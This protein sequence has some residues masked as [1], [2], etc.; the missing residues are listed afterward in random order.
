M[1]QRL[2]FTVHFCHRKR[3][4]QIVEPSS[5]RY[6]RTLVESLSGSNCILVERSDSS[7]DKRMVIVVGFR[8]GAHSLKVGLAI[9]QAIRPPGTVGLTSLPMLQAGLSAEILPQPAYC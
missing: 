7:G 9:D 5:L 1:L 2:T 6:A 8:R 3:R 4:L